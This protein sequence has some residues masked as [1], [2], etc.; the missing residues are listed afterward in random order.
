MWHAHQK[1]IQSW[2]NVEFLRLLT[3]PGDDLLIHMS[4]YSYHH[5]EGDEAD[6]DATDSLGVNIG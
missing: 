1:W 3:F 2:T 6:L 4:T 5:I